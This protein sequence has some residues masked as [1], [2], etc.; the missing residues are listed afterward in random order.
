MSLHEALNGTVYLFP[1]T[2]KTLQDLIRNA[3]DF[4]PDQLSFILV[5]LF[6]IV[7]QNPHSSASLFR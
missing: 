3:L 2:R 6:Q 1:T 4:E 5:F 7:T